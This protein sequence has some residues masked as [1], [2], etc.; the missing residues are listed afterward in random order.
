ME[1]CPLPHRLHP[2]AGARPATGQK[3]SK[4][5]GQRD[6]PAGPDRQV[7]R[8]RAPL[9]A[10]VDGGAGPRHQAR[11]A[12]RVAGYRNFATKLWNAA[13]FCEANGCTPAPDFR[14]RRTSV[15]PST[16]GSWA[17]CARPPTRGR[18]QAHRCLP[19]RRRRRARSTT[20]PG[21]SFCDWYLEFSK[22]IAFR[23]RG[24]RRRTRLGPRRRGCWTTILGLCSIPI[25]PFVTRRSFGGR[26]DE[27][28]QRAC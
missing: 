13:R 9:H 19:L 17:R 16:A 20:S 15:R 24:R 10:G 21:M 5:Q 8:R 12:S 7:R 2:C 18:P 27:R 11:R 1:R 22:P 3:M 6:R 23:G 28:P 14:S 4:S 25:M 26:I